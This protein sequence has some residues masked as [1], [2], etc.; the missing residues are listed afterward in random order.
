MCSP[1]R[2]DYPEDGG[3]NLLQNHS[4][5]Q[6]YIGIISQKMEIL[7]SVLVAKKSILLKVI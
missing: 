7:I 2:A 1:R 5:I 3:S 6:L 4:Y